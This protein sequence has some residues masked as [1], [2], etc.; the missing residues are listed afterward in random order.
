MVD[1]L[2][3]TKKKGLKSFIDG[4][5]GWKKGGIIGFL[6]G[7]CLALIFLIVDGV[8]SWEYLVDD[9]FF[10]YILPAVLIFILPI[11]LIGMY[12]GFLV[13]TKNKYIKK[14]GIFGQKT[15]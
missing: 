13:S 9:P 7:F 10:G 6:I 14:G 4:L 8:S 2:R 11:S 5:S 3:N 1:S 12:I 15:A